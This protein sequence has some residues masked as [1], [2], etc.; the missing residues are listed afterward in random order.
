MLSSRE[1]SEVVRLEASGLPL[2]QLLTW[3]REICTSRQG[4]RMSNVLQQLSQ[5]AK[6]WRTSHV[7]DKYQQELQLSK[8]DISHALEDLIAEVRR[9]EAELHE[10][11]VRS[12]LS[13]VTDQLSQLKHR[14]LLAD[15]QPNFLNLSSIF[16]VLRSLNEEVQ[17]RISLVLP[18]DIQ[19][20]IQARVQG[21]LE[22]ELNRAR[23]QDFIVT[24]RAVYWMLL[25]AELGLPEIHLSI[26]DQW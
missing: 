24:Q 9:A 20:R 8:A 22:R 4:Q 16:D 11:Q 6:R 25:S 2:P 13:W 1:L 5:R 21:S 15:D 18:F 26:F 23:P 7:G 19:Q 10:P 14:A 12:V 3:A 17:E